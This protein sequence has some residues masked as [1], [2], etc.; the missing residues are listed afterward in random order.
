MSKKYLYK[1]MTSMLGF[2]R[3]SD[4]TWVKADVSY[5]YFTK[6]HLMWN[7]ALVVPGLAFFGLIIPLLLLQR[8]YRMRKDLFNIKLREKF[9]YL[10]NE[11]REESWF[12]E[13]LKNV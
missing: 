4:E 2:R 6:S 11:Y 13:I 12:W 10:I 9:S 3:I 7:F 5:K 1:S 8:L